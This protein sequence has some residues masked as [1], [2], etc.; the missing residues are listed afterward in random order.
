MKVMIELYSN[1]LGFERTSQEPCCF[2]GHFNLKQKKAT[3]LIVFIGFANILYC[4][5]SLEASEQVCHT[6]IKTVL[7]LFLMWISVRL[8]QPYK[9]DPFK[10][11]SVLWA[12]QS[13]L[14]KYFKEKTNYTE[15]FA[16]SLS[17]TLCFKIT[18]SIS[19]SALDPNSPFLSQLA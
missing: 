3:K 1:D 17:S 10:V 2:D 4:P 9:N 8:K 14:Q 19:M 15:D 13:C 16:V 12:K 5:I 11:Q 18:P 6:L 7:F